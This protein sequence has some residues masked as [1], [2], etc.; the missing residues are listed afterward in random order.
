MEHGSN[1][2]RKKNGE[3][4]VKPLGLKAVEKEHQSTLKFIFENESFFRT[5]RKNALSPYFSKYEVNYFFLSRLL[6]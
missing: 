5:N 3:T 2:E 1:V 6:G 4:P